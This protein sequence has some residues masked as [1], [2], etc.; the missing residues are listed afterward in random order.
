VPDELPAVVRLYAV[1]LY[2]PLLTTFLPGGYHVGWGMLCSLIVPTIQREVA[3][4]VVGNEQ[5]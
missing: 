4:C 3:G 5:L 2:A 1:C